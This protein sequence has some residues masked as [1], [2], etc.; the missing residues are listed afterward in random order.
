MSDGVI[1]LTA[2]REAGAS[3]PR[4]RSAG[5]D[6][7]VLRAVAE[8]VGAVPGVARV[9]SGGLG[10]LATYLPGERLNGVRVEGRTL[11]LSIV[12]R[13]GVPL[14]ELARA[15]RAAAAWDGPVD[16]TVADLELGD[17][18]G[19]EHATS[20]DRTSP[21]RTDRDRT[22]AAARTGPGEPPASAPMG[23]DPA[24]VAELVPAVAPPR[25]AGPTDPTTE[26]TH[27]R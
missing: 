4:T 22:D 8:R 6:P 5:D 13:D 12:A 19:D 16:V 2:D 24:E 23:G 9:G 10:E 27:G 17:P 26:G 3:D 15:V 14:P 20:P 18:T 7:A 1:D 11:Q 21:D 25:P